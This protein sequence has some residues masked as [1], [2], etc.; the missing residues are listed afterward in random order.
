MVMKKFEYVDVNTLYEWIE[1][2]VS[3][4]VT[5]PCKNNWKTNIEYIEGSSGFFISPTRP[6]EKKREPGPMQVRLITKYYAPTYR[7]YKE[8][9]FKNQCIANHFGLDIIGMPMNSSTGKVIS[10]LQNQTRHKNYVMT[11]RE[12]SIHRK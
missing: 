9:Y 5:F 10:Y 2:E 6:E 12:A 4:L 11:V 1:F 7:L 8:Y 3:E